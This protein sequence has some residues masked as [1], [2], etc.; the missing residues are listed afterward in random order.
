MLSKV[1]PDVTQRNIPLHKVT[2]CNMIPNYF[3][4]YEEMFGIQLNRLQLGVYIPFK[5][6]SMS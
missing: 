6:C 3:F 5:L 1:L 2:L 4:V